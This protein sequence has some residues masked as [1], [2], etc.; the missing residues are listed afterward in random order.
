MDLK[1]FLVFTALLLHA[2][3]G[4][5]IQENY[6]NS[7]AK[8]PSPTET[9]SEDEVIFNRILKVNKEESHV[10][11]I[12]D[13]MA[14]FETLT[15]INFVKRKTERD[16][17]SIKSADGCWSNYG[18]VGGGQTVSVMKGGCTW[19]GI[20]QHELDHALGFLHEH[21]RSDRDKHVKIMWDYISP[22]DRP[23]FKKFENSNNLGL[24][25]DYSSVMHY[26]P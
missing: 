23:D 11:G 18:K 25:Y 12:H 13:A 21:S 15:C 17:L 22:A 16:Y 8:S 7:T 19:K 3:L 14:E 26:G 6:G 5:P 10:K 1:M 2:T 24:P 20:I 9:Y 4:F